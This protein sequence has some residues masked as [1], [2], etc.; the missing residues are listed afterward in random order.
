MESVGH[1]NEIGSSESNF[2]KETPRRIEMDLELVP[3][4]SCVTLLL[5]L[6]CCPCDEQVVPVLRRV[7]N[8]KWSLFVPCSPELQSNLELI[9]HHFTELA[10]YFSELRKYLL[11]QIP[12]RM[13]HD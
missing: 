1:I 6:K 7:T 13:T 5:V 11:L 12:V 10:E 2:F 9:N 3:C 4:D 8:T